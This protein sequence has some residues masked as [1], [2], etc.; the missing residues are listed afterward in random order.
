MSLESSDEPGSR[1]HGNEHGET[2]HGGQRWRLIDDPLVVRAL[3]HPIR[4]DLLAIV[5]RLGRATTAD[6]AR[7]LGISHGLASHHLQQLA[8]YGFVEQITGKD[9]RERPW[10]LV[11]TSYNWR[12]VTSTPDGAAAV[13]V[14]EQVFAERALD[15]F[16]SWQQRRKS[17]PREW[18]EHTGIGRTTVYLTLDEVAGLTADIDAL[19]MHYADERPLDDMAARPAGSVPV[20]FTFFAVP[21]AVHAPEGQAPE[22]E[23]PEAG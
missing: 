9:N 11:A 18:L 1:Q 21:N 4:Q 22:A 5:G 13:D 16:L 23:A 15:G 6:A 2:E 7:E 3:A 10:R 17:W 14:A 19:L 12:G 20:D 8:K